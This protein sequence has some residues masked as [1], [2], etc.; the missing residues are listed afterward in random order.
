MIYSWLKTVIA[1]LY[2][3]EN[4]LS[5]FQHDAEYRRP[6]MCGNLTEVSS[7]R[8]QMQFFQ[9]WMKELHSNLA[10]TNPYTV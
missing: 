6:S 7:L 4:F 3:L 10:I 2:M 1:N 8:L 5:G 9:L